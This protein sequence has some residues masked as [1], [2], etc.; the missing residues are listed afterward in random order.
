MA[1]ILQPL[2]SDATFSDHGF[3]LLMLLAA[4][5][6]NKLNETGHGDAL[7]SH[8]AL[9]AYFVVRGMEIF[10]TFN[11]VSWRLRQFKMVRARTFIPIMKAGGQTG[12]SAASLRRHP[13]LIT[14]VPSNLLFPCSG[15]H[16]IRF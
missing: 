8:S 7:K 13:F 12:P 10:M 16:S 4:N 2:R 15:S 5:K 6:A 11:P 9:A 14:I 3:Q 1:Q